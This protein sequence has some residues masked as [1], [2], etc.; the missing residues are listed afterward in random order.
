MKVDEGHIRT[1][2]PQRDSRMAIYWLGEPGDDGFDL[3]AEIEQGTLSESAAD[4][5]S[6]ASQL[7]LFSRMP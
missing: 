1:L 3:E 6:V 2:R 4:S 7:S 5:S